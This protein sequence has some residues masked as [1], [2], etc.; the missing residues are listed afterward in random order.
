MEEE[1]YDGI[2]YSAVN[3]SRLPSMLTWHKCRD[4]YPRH[5]YFWICS[6]WSELIS[7]HDLYT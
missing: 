5:A 7:F 2:N 1:M 6:Q 4:Q 3:T